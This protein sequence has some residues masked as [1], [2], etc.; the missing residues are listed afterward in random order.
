MNWGNIK[1]NRVQK[2]NSGEIE[3]MEGET[4][5]DNKDYKNT[6]KLTWLAETSQAPLTPV[7][8][9]HYDNIMTK[10]KLDEGDKFENF[11]NY[12][13]KTE[14]DIIGEP[15][16][17]QL[18]QGDII[19]ILRKGYYICDTPYDAATQQSC[20]LLNIPD[21]G[22]KEKPTSLKATDTAAKAAGDTSKSSVTSGPEVDQLIEQIVQQGEKV[23]ELKTNK[24]TPKDDVN[25]AVKQLLALKEQYKKLTGSEY[26]P[27]TASAAASTQKENQKPASA[28]STQKENQKPV[29][30]ASSST[31]ATSA[32]DEKLA[33]K[34]TQQGDKVRELKA[35]KS[36]SKEEVTAAV[37][38]LLKLK[39]QYKTLTGQDVSASGGAAPA[40][41]EKGK[42]TSRKKT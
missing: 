11:V 18:K 10:V 39:E 40:R 34:I 4:Q 7:T 28:A 1:V 21:G 19:Q 3:F 37:Q 12:A 42:K 9:V 20:R 24:S 22:T 14:Y 13:S 38:E 25:A 26:K 6:L 8:C 17:A 31:S 2:N 36:A 29:S 32:E 5:L 33:E 35:N 27:S 30:A 16:L 41:K 23:R 15:D